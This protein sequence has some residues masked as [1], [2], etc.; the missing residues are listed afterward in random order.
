MMND[1]IRLQAVAGFFCGK[2]TSAANTASAAFFY[3]TVKGK[4]TN[5]KIL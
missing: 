4:V 5:T 1:K 3:M 2:G